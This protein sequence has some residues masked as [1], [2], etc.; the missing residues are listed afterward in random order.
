MDR[1]HIKAQFD[2]FH[3]LFRMDFMLDLNYT[4]LKGITG[5]EVDRKLMGTEGIIPSKAVVNRAA[6]IVEALMES[7]AISKTGKPYYTVVAGGDGV[8][9]NHELVLLDILEASEYT[10]RVLD[11][12]NNVE[13][14]EKPAPAE[15]ACSGDG[16]IVSEGLHAFCVGF[17]IL[18]KT[19]KHWF[20]EVDKL[21]DREGYQ[22]RL[23]IFPVILILGKDSKERVNTFAAAFLYWCL[24]VNKYGLYIDNTRSPGSA[25]IHISVNI[26]CL[27]DLL[28][29]WIVVDRGHSLNCFVCGCKD[30]RL[31]PTTVPNEEKHC[32]VC[33]YTE[34]E[35][36]SC[37]HQP[38]V[39]QVN[40][41]QMVCDAADVI[42]ITPDEPPEPPADD[43]SL[44]AGGVTLEEQYKSYYE[45]RRDWVS[46]I[47]SHEGQEKYWTLNYFVAVLTEKEVRALYRAKEYKVLEGLIHLVKH[48][49]YPKQ[50]KNIT[51]GMSADT[52][53][54][55]LKS[56]IAGDVAIHANPHRHS[57]SLHIDRYKGIERLRKYCTL[58]DIKLPRRHTDKL[59]KELLRGWMEKAYTVVQVR[60]KSFETVKGDP[61][62]NTEDVPP[63]VLHAF[64]RVM[65]KYIWLNARWVFLAFKDNVAKATKT[66]ERLESYINKNL[67]TNGFAGEGEFKFRYKS[68]SV[69]GEK[70]KLKVLEPVNLQARRLKPIAR[71]LKGLAQ[72]VK[73]A[74]PK[75][76]RKMFVD[77]A[78]DVSWC[79]LWLY[80]D[81]PG[82]KC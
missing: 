28:F 34:G 58:L 69:D 71:D 81:D 61:K 57:N 4:T 48:L 31:L 70:G 63:D 8:I 82:C 37:V 16:S 65:G 25:K 15:L 45:S 26:K 74:L 41:N 67:L 22:D 7:R 60:A 51:S 66:I 23:T 3:L 47:F 29:E 72:I 59:V 50:F 12:A 79:V 40:L 13:G 56:W 20:H 10:K 18:D 62:M 27:C 46:A 78:N 24:H 52:V 9:L 6:R 39:D 2:K 44:D 64:L 80:G 43:V 30:V 33:C 1:R 38:L 55:E 11:W 32:C 73:K 54:K 53:V 49:S 14:A 75:D 36:A 17:K 42:G 76:K 5:L 68:G 19:F 77:L 35:V 21:I